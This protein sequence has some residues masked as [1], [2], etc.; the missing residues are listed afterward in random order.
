MKFELQEGIVTTDNGHP[1]EDATAENEEVEKHAAET[2]SQV[3]KYRFG[4]KLKSRRENDCVVLIEKDS[5]VSVERNV[6]LR[7]KRERKKNK[8]MKEERN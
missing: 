6:K 4:Q 7:Q 8:N 1:T 5:N 2:T 3:R